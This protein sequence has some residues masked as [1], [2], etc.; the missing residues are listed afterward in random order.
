MKKVLVCFVIVCLF[1]TSSFAD[2]PNK[3]MHKQCFHPTVKIKT[4]SNQEEE[5]GVGTGV[6]IRSVKKLGLATSPSEDVYTNVVITSAHNISKGS[7]F[8]DVPKFKNWSEITGY[9]RFP[10]AVFAASRQYDI[11]VLFFESPTVLPVAELDFDTKYFVGSDV[12]KFGYGTGDECRLDHGEITLI[13]SKTPFI[14]HI[15]INAHTIFGDS[16]GPCFLKSNYKV[17]GLVKAIRGY[18]NQYLTHITYVTPL[19]F[20]KTF[21]QETQNQLAFVID[22]SVPIPISFVE[23]QKR[24]A[25]LNYKAQLEA[26]KKEIMA[27]NQILEKKKEMQESIEKEIKRIEEDQE[28]PTPKMPDEP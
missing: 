26:I 19:S 1:I 18:Q 7:I 10:G 15:R 13:S 8:I 28:L 11:A 17:I 21:N 23:L 6:I 3:K 2:E 9:D 4:L 20:L 12:L 16:G 25:L 27:V 24:N 14:N 5:G 22:S